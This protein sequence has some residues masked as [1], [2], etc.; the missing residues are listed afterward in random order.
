MSA[1]VHPIGYVGLALILVALLVLAPLA[2][3]NGE[4]TQRRR[5][6]QSRR[7]PCA[8][9]RHVRIVE[10]PALTAPEARAALHAANQRHDT[11]FYDQD[12]AGDG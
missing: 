2:H 8:E 6:Q 12:G 4:H 1:C 10:V 9:P 11:T 5:E 7:H 3:V